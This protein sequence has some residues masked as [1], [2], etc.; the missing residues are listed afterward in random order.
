MIGDSANGK[1]TGI[2]QLNAKGTIFKTIN[3]PFVVHL[4]LG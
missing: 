2:S 3:I 4:C 1:L